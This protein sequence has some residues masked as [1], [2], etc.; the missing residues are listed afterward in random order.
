MK[1]LTIR[2][3]L[4][5][6]TI[7][8]IIGF[9]ILIFEM[10]FT[11]KE[12]TLLKNT[13]T[14][15][16]LLEADMLML[17]RNEKDFIIRTDL[18]YKNIF[19]EN[20]DNFY[21]RLDNLTKS[22]TKLGL[23]TKNIKEYESIL[24]EYENIFYKFVNKQIEIGLN[25]KSGLNGS[26]RKSVHNIQNIAQKS[27][28]FELLAN[29]YD[30][31]KHEKDFM[32]RR[33]LKYVE[34]YNK[35]VN[36][37]L[38]SQVNDTVSKYLLAY[39]KDFL[40]LVKN[41]QEKGL[42]SSLGIQGEMR[43]TIHKTETILKKI[44]ET[45]SA[46]IVSTIEEEN[47]KRYITIAI[48]V[49]LVIGL[50]FYISSLLL[51]NIRTFREGLTDFFAYLNKQTKETKELEVYGKDAI[52]N[53][54][55]MVND[56][57][58]KIRKQI[59]SDEKF[60]N[61]VIYMVEDIKKGYLDKRFENQVE[62]HNLE[63]LRLNMNEMLENLNDI[64]GKNTNNILDILKSF[65]ELDFTNEIKNDKA[66][67]PVSLNNVNK[68]ITQMLIEN[69]SN[70]L[71]LEKSSNILMKNVESLSSAS[72]ETAVSL[73][74]T[75]AAL[76]EI[77]SNISSNTENIIQMSS[78]TNELTGSTNIGKKLAS[79]TTISMDEINQEVNAIN[80]AI[81]VIDQIAFQTNILS[82]NAA[83]EAATAGEAGKGFAVVA[84][85]VR[86]LASRSAQAASE[87]KT[88]VETATVK[89]NN[90]KEIADKMIEGY[91]GLNSN[92]NKTIEL[93]SNI[94][95]ASKEQLKGVEQINK[96]IN[97]LDKQTQKN[98]E[99]ALQTKS[100]AQATL[101]ISNIIV[102]DVDSKKFIGKNSVQVKE[103]ESIESNKTD[104]CSQTKE[105]KEETNIKDKE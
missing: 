88:L 19:K 63:K 7:V 78:Y 50:S 72:N 37:I 100:I 30:L 74:E 91:N 102:Q 56:N 41:E 99:V 35:V 33:D 85:E 3:K 98:A 59:E 44:E 69:K 77:T 28:N 92:V 94:E 70:G 87:I 26:L 73:E 60:I 23:N 39:Q 84:Q 75:A 40:L 105:E 53:M 22:L 52:S 27:D 55:I 64:I 18:K 79:K 25:H 45:I 58:V 16:R 36:K 51:K 42:T 11:V 29:I 6:S 17:R 82:L 32:L 89:A 86:N 8:T 81:T 101:T 34:N 66:K 49:L 65:S 90:G 47:I 20:I 31:R 13:E 83:V 97:A 104:F 67:I 1:N 12:L 15:I 10:N 48:I 43:N 14:N 4:F 62:S 96:A 93:I 61:E 76:E 9:V 5:I 54:S 71:T 68:L 103:I 2:Q 95:M 38:S 24:K 46:E 21:K 57:I 80:E